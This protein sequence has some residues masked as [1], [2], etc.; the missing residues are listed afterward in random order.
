MA[1]I[2]V[3]DH[4]IETTNIMVVEAGTNCPQGGDKGHGGRTLIRFQ[5]LSNTA[6]SGRIND[7]A[8]VPAQKIEIILGGD[9]ENE[10]MIE[11]LEFAAKV[12]RG[13]TQRLSVAR[14]EDIN[15]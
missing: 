5:D 11:A 2:N 9:A 15:L 14:V 13:K 3:Y 4:K 10:T 7:S 8:L 12:L 1:K 6:I